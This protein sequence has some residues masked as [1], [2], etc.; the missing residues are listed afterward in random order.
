MRSRP[1]GFLSLHLR[2]PNTKLDALSCALAIN[3]IL[4]RLGLGTFDGQ[5]QVFILE[6]CL[7]WFLDHVQVNYTRSQRAFNLFKR[8]IDVPESRFIVN[9]E[10]PYVEMHEQMII[11]KPVFTEC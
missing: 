8:S 9:M 7:V 1:L 10:T 11:S 5:R 6:V 4:L 2:S 3:Q